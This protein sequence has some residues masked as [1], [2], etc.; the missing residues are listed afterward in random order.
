MSEA[1]TQDELGQ[2]IDSWE[3]YQHWEF[4][5][6]AGAKVA[7]YLVELQS[8]RAALQQARYILAKIG[9][10]AEASELC[11]DRIPAVTSGT[12][13]PLIRSVL[14]APGREKEGRP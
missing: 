4:T 6:D 7:A 8:T 12:L 9:V 1:E 5:V 10:L 2:L 11:G 13:L 14:A 3:I